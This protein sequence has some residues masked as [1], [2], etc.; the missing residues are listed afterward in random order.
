MKGC[1]LVLFS[2][3]ERRI[4]RAVRVPIASHISLRPATVTTQHY[5]HRPWTDHHARN[6]R[7]HKRGRGGGATC[8]N[9]VGFARE[10][11]LPSACDTQSALAL[12]FRNPR[13]FPISDERLGPSSRDRQVGVSFSEH[14]RAEN[15]IRD[16]GISTFTP[17]ARICP[18]MCQPIRS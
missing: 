4:Q 14:G 12:F 8:T 16:S 15:R 5:Y 2:K 9:V 13:H 17:F 7:S 10:S 3:S 18:G 11:R 6:I 1:R